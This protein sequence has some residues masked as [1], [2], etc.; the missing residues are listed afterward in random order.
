VNY[1]GSLAQPTVERVR[2]EIE[3]VTDGLRLWGFVTV[4]NNETQHATVITPQ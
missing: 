3:P 2:L 1:P 4:V